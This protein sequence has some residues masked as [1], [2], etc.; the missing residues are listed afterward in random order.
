MKECIVWQNWD[1]Y[2]YLVLLTEI[3]VSYKK[4]N[5]SIENHPENC[6]SKI[7]QKRAKERRSEQN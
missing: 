7:L 4:S 5:K 2:E 1:T 6:L 3:G